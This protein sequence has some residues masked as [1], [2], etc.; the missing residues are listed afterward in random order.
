[1]N[2]KENGII[3][4]LMDMLKNIIIKIKNYSKNIP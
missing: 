3:I 1:M 4:I 2:M